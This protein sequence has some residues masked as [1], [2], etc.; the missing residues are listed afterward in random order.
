[1]KR[2]IVALAIFSISYCSSERCSSE[3]EGVQCESITVDDINGFSCYK[4]SY[5]DDLSDYECLALPE[6]ISKLKPFINLFIGMS[7][8]DMSGYAYY[9]KSMNDDPDNYE[10]YD[11]LSKDTYSK[12][13]VITFKEE[14]Y[15]DEDIKII[16]GN[17]TCTYL[18]NGKVYDELRQLGENMNEYKNIEDKTICFNAEQFSELKD[19]V[20]CGY[21]KIKYVSEGKVYNI[22]TC[23]YIPNNKMP[24]EFG[25]YF[26]KEYVDTLFEDEESLFPQIFY[27]IENHNEMMPDA[28]GY[29]RLSSIGFEVEVENKNG[30]KVKY[31]DSS[32]DIEV[33]EKG[34]E[35]TKDLPKDSDSE[36]TKEPEKNNNSKMFKFNILLLLISLLY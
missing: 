19:L 5:E 2:I 10:T 12:A 28:D 21:A 25:A 15:S 6:D 14:S 17:K 27:S 4:T 22:K 30:K 35:E 34:S 11:I 16:N 7:K 13:E 24:E 1:M 31:T 18:F 36:Q 33:I 3:S 32:N 26:K 8:E 23:F 9:I 20:D 29:R